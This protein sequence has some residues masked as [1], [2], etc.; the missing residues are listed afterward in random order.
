MIVD[1]P[2]AAIVIAPITGPIISASAATIEA[3]R[4]FTALARGTGFFDPEFTAVVCGAVYGTDGR[5]SFLVIRHFYKSKATRAV[6][7]AISGDRYF[8]DLAMGGEDLA[9][10]LLAV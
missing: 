5:V 6:G 8:V 4:T 3:S 7:V 10:L 2:A 1:L 9:N